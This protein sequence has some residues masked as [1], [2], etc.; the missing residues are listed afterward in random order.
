MRTM[1]DPSGGWK[2]LPAEFDKGLICGC[3]H[4]VQTCGVRSKDLF[5]SGFKFAELEM[6]TCFTCCDVYDLY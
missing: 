1:G 4:L 3:E 2:L 6:S 5:Y